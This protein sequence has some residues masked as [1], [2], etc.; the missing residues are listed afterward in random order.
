M[1]TRWQHLEHLVPKCQNACFGPCGP[2]ERLI[3]LFWTQNRSI[4]AVISEL[5]SNHDVW[6]LCFICQLILVNCSHCLHYNYDSLPVV[7]CFKQPEHSVLWITTVV[8][9]FDNCEWLLLQNEVQS[10]VTKTD[11][12]GCNH[13]VETESEFY[14]KIYS[15]YQER[16]FEV[17][18]V[19][20]AWLRV[21]LRPLLK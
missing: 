11:Y 2:A 13:N 18:G 5:C 10:V 17:L 21:V 6:T 15:H 4:E 14:A 20:N 12:P 19:S 8:Y 1:Q 7:L 3:G 16:W 9:R